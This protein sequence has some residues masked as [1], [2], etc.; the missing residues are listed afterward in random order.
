MIHLCCRKNL[1]RN[2]NYVLKIHLALQYELMSHLDPIAEFFIIL[3]LK[4]VDQFSLLIKIKV[5]FS[6]FS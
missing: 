3:F 4:V 6:R 2:R 1:L 5:D